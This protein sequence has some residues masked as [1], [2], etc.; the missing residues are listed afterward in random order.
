MLPKL[1]YELTSEQ[2]VMLLSS[3]VPFFLVPLFM[4][5]DMASRISHFM[6]AGIAAQQSAKSQ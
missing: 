6:R 3:Y 4:T 2:R 1:G 5:F